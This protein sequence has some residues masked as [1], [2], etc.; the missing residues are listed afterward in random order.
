MLIVK[1]SRVRPGQLEPEPLV[2][3]VDQEVARKVIELIRQS[4]SQ[5]L[6]DESVVVWDES[7]ITVP[8]RSWNDGEC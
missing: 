1:V 2:A 4:L 5:E 3:T 7:V 8:A 6:R